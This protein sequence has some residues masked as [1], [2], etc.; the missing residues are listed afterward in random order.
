VK[1]VERGNSRKLGDDWRILLDQVE[2]GEDV[3]AKI[4][5]SFVDQGGVVIEYGH[6]GTEMY[7]YMRDVAESRA[8]DLRKIIPASLVPAKSP[9]KFLETVAG[10]VRK[11]VRN[12]CKRVK[13]GEIRPHMYEERYG[14]YSCNHPSTGSFYLVIDDNEDT[15]QGVTD[16]RLYAT[17]NREEAMEEYEKLLEEMEGGEP[18]FRE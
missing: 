2:V 15:L 4:M 3:A 12:F 18:W 14:V 17:R 16:I 5:S 13:G 1:F 9:E 8:E 10:A 11:F 7:R 6:P